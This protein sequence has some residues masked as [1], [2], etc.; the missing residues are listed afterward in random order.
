VTHHEQLLHFGG[1]DQNR[2]AF[3]RERVK[4][5]IDLIFGLDIDAAS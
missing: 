2:Y 1:S 3:G 5:V 4:E